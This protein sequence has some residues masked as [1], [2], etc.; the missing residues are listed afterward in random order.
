M[1]VVMMTILLVMITQLISMYSISKTC[2]H[3]LYNEERLEIKCIC[4]TT[5]GALTEMKFIELLKGYFY[6]Y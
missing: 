1:S 6:Q 3:H 5:P 2:F 4:T